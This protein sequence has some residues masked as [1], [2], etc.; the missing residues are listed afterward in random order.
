[1]KRSDACGSSC[2]SPHPQ[3]ILSIALDRQTEPNYLINLLHMHT[4]ITHTLHDGGG[5]GGGG[6]DLIKADNVV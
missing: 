3:P 1:M 5:G 6:G 2:F 4:Q